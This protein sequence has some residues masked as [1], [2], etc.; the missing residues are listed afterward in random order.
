MNEEN[1]GSWSDEQI[2][3][4]EH[5]RW[6]K[7]Q[8]MGGEIYDKEKREGKEGKEEGAIDNSPL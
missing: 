6:L 3:E 4:W 8:E 5:D 2:E 7:M 1:K